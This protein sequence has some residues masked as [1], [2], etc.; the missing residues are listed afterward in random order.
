MYYYKPF[1]NILVVCDYRTAALN[2]VKY[3]VSCGIAGNSLILNPHRYGLP[4]A[5]KI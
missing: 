1:G 3:L 2:C 5:K 4:V